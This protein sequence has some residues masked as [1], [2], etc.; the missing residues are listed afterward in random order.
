[1][2]FQ[3]WAYVTIDGV[4]K[5]AY[6]VQ[7]PPYHNFELGSTAADDAMTEQNFDLAKLQYGVTEFLS[8]EEYKAYLP[9]EN[10]T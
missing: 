3:T 9:L 1:M 8:E 2:L 6:D 4:K 7:I 5:V 10:Q